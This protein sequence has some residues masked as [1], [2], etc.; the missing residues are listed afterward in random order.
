MRRFRFLRNRR[1]IFPAVNR[2]AFQPRP[3]R[4]GVFLINGLPN[5]YIKS[6]LTGL[7]QKLRRDHGH[8]GQIVRHPSA[9]I[10]AV[11]KLLII[12]QGFLCGQTAGITQPVHRRFHKRIIDSLAVIHAVIVLKN[13]DKGVQHPIRSHNKARHRIFG[14]RN[15]PFRRPAL[16]RINAAGLLPL[17]PFCDHLYNAVLLLHDHSVVPAVA[18]IYVNPIVDR[19]GQRGLEIKYRLLRLIGLLFHLALSRVKRAGEYFLNLRQICQLIRPVSALLP[20]G[21]LDIPQRCR[22]CKIRTPMGQRAAS[23][24]VRNGCGQNLR[25]FQP[26]DIAVILARN[27]S[28]RNMGCALQRN[29]ERAYF[30]V[31]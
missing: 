8:N 18:A 7:T 30:P 27:A 3:D 9:I 20:H 26:A 2:F 4:I 29:G 24:A 1:R 13:R 22:H 23:H 6:W 31:L 28:P 25:R 17:E 19:H 10:R 5:I 21:L 16:K 12:R 11:Q 14:P 15:L